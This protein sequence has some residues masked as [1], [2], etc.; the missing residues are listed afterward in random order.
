MFP[1]IL[2]QIMCRFPWIAPGSG[3]L[4]PPASVWT[5]PS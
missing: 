3:L 5:G 4:L 1:V 2:P